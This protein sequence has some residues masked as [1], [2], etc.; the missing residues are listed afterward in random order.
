MDFI[1]IQDQAKLIYGKMILKMHNTPNS[2]MS[3]SSSSSSSAIY[4]K[5]L[6]SLLIFQSHLSFAKTSLT[7]EMPK[8]SFCELDA[9]DECKETD[10]VRHDPHVQKTSPSIFTLYAKGR[11]IEMFLIIFIKK[12]NSLCTLL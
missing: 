9:M 1:F 7:I 11:V 8:G 4:P 6:L 12:I 10:C 3:S 5:L 2:N